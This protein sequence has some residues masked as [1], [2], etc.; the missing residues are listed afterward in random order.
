[1]VPPS[2]NIPKGKLP[3]LQVDLVDELPGRGH[4]DGFGLLLLTEG[5]GC[6]AVG[7]ELLQDGEQEGSLGGGDASVNE[8]LGT[9]HHEVGILSRQRGTPTLRA[10]P[11]HRFAGP[12]LG[13]GHEVPGSRDDGDAVL[14]HRRRLHVTRLADVF[15]Q[16]L[17]QSRLIKGLK[18][19]ERTD[20]RWRV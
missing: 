1:M 2:G 3:G 8:A 7:H 15:P 18:G 9:R 17:A 19:T 13:A 16:G 20:Y 10:S 11:T 6:H 5:T 14:L 12:R 4:D